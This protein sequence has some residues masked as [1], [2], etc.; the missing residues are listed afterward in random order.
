MSVSSFFIVLRF[1]SF[2]LHRFINTVTDRGVVFMNNDQYK[3]C[4]YIYI[5]IYTHIYIYIYTHT[6]CTYIHTYVYPIFF[7][8]G[9]ALGFTMFDFKHYVMKIVLE[10]PNLHQVRLHEKL[11]LTEK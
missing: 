10:S 11:K 7:W 5:Y 1:I 4:M 6:Y 2:K 9:G 3:I 8:G